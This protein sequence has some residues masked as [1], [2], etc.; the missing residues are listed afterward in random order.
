MTREEA[1]QAYEE[2]LGRIALEA[3]EAREKTRE[4]LRGHLQSLR[5]ECH[6]ELKA[7]RALEQKTKKREC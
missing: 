5:E 2:A 7:I 6:R 3:L 4:I 1:Y